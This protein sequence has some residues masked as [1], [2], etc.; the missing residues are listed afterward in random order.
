MVFLNTFNSG[1]LTPAFMA[2]FND[3]R[4]K[5]ENPLSALVSDKSANS[6]EP[7]RLG[8][9][10]TEMTMIGFGYRL[11]PSA[12][13]S[14]QGFDGVYVDSTD[15]HLFLTESK[16]RQEKKSVTT[17]MKENLDEGTFHGR[18][19]SMPLLN[20]ARQT[21]EQFLKFAPQS[22]F[23]FVHRI[24]PNG[25]A[26]CCVERFDFFAYQLLFFKSLS[27]ASSDF[28]KI[29][30]LQII[31]SKISTSP[32]EALQLMLKS[33][34]LSKEQGAL[35]LTSP[36]TATTGG[37]AVATAQ[38]P[39][40]VKLDV[41]PLPS[42]PLSE[43]GVLLLAAPP[44]AATGGGTAAAQAPLQ[45]KLEALPLPSESPPETDVKS[46]PLVDATAP[47]KPPSSF[48]TPTKKAEP[49]T[50]P[51]GAYSPE[52]LQ[53]LMQ[54]LNNGDQIMSHQGI[55]RG[56]LAKFYNENSGQS[57]SDTPFRKLIG[58]SR[59]GNV[60]NSLGI[61]QVFTQ[62]FDALCDKFKVNKAVILKCMG[63]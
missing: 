26:Q 52:K 63:G 18:L 20:P 32:L 55:G 22:I 17:Y 4:G 56:G 42:E 8:E 14:N 39:L 35:L 34:N 60:Q 25:I 54:L 41:L 49:L 2:A 6:N 36:P 40:Q 38:A 43:Q 48:Q 37:K 44:T 5:T 28:D 7:W 47:A 23:K 13:A 53:K 31:T 9:L 33:L 29:T 15:Q 62:N 12:N 58:K 19:Q 1:D 50:T 10:A 57:L 21:I 61:W 11:I 24:K 45:V 27:P 16:C 30:V 3:T 51:F 46:G 59:T